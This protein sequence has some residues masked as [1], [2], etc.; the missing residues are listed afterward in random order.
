MKILKNNKEKY[1]VRIL[2]FSEWKLGGTRHNTSK[3]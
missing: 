1:G 3:G 2:R